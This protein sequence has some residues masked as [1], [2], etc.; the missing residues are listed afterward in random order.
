MRRNAVEVGRP[1]Y[2]WRDLFQGQIV[3]TACDALGRTFP[4]ECGQD[5]DLAATGFADRATVGDGTSLPTN[6]RSQDLEMG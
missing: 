4:D 2:C 6:V 3:R 1:P 5:Y